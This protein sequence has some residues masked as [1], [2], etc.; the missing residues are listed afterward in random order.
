MTLAME[1]ASPADPARL[2]DRVEAARSAGNVNEAVRMLSAYWAAGRSPAAAQYTVGQF[3]DLVPSL[4][5]TRCRMAILR[6]FSVEPVVPVVRAGAFTAGIE[7]EVRLSGFNAYMQELLETDGALRRFQPDVTVL[8]VHGMDI[9]PDLWHDYTGL[10]SAGRTRAIERVCAHFRD[11]IE[12]FRRGFNGHLIVHNLEQPTFQCA[13]VLDTQ[14]VD[15]QRAAFHEINTRLRKMAGEHRGVYVLDYDALVARHGREP[16]TDR[17]KWV[18]MRMPVAASRLISIAD[19]WLRFLHPLT[20]KVVKALAVDLDNTLWGGVLGED[21]V[22]GI[23]LG[24][25][26]PGAAFLELQRALVDLHRRGIMLAIAS[27][28]NDDEAWNAVSTHEGMLLKP[29]HFAARRIGWGSKADS[30][31][32]IATELNIGLGAIAFLDD[33]PVERQQMRMQ[34]PEVHVIELPDDVLQYAQAVRDCPLFERLQLSDE[35]RKRNEFYADQKKREELI[36]RCATTEDFLRSLRQVAEIAPAGPATIARVAQLTQKTNQ[37]N[38]TTRRYT[39][40]AVAELAARDDA[41]VFSIRITD[42]F[43]DNG[44]TGVAIL[45]YTS[46]CCEID[47]FLLSCRVIGRSV[48]TALLSFV[49]AQARRRGVARLLGSYIPTAANAPAADFYPRH[50]FTRVEDSGAGSRFELSPAV[51]DVK[52]PEWIATP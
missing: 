48:E 24:R 17:R 39:E 51:Q 9:A 47:T 35:D 5:L 52:W 26:Y 22:H 32:E 33:N 14:A 11:C 4:S 50:G 19:E 23:R 15:N 28:N 46:Q 13:G 7:L 49:C 18:T 30:L 2:R 25:E 3:E 1:V 16:W 21:G 31:R 45:R 38:L 43:N 27:K 29:A 37:F 41:E 20:G 44:I 8:A 10:D 34:L 6:S 42:T 40:T 12:A 36:A